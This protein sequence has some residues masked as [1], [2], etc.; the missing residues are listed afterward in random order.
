MKFIG[1]K[2]NGTWRRESVLALWLSLDEATSTE[3]LD[4][5]KGHWE[6]NERD[7]LHSR[8]LGSD[9]LKVS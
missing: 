1:K 2:R 7:N 4:L 5:A 8:D 6:S 9:S 3:G